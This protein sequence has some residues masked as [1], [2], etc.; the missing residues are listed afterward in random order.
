MAYTIRGR[1]LLAAWLGATMLLA[2]QGALAQV[3]LDNESGSSFKGTR[4]VAISQFGVEFYTQLTVVGRSGGNTAKQ[5]STLTGVGEATM[6][7]LTDQLY[8]DT[9]A[10]LKEA[11]FEVVDPAV[12]AADAG[13]QALA[14]DPG[15]P[16]PYLV[17]DSQGVA[18]GEHLSKVFAPAGMRAFYQSGGSSGGNL[19]GNMGDRFNSQ[20]QGTAGKEGEIAKRLNATLLK[21]S[22]LANYGLTK[23]SKNGMLAVFANTASRVSLETAPVLVPHDTQV[24]FVDATAPRVFG[25]IKR[26]GASGAFYLDKPLQ[27]ANIFETAETTPAETKKSDGVANAVFSLFGTKASGKSQVLEV[28]ASDDA[29]KAAFAALLASADDALIAAL[30]SN[31]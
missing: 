5:V 11:G 26:P 24:Q 13:Y 7:A 14:A 1:R 19:R 17:H 8:A 15:K 4:R 23:A 3:S 31:R 28:S 16:S 29:Y 30:K 25:N 27:G 20:N 10:R 6:Q 22:F 9:V 12:L 18:D 2:A 21:F